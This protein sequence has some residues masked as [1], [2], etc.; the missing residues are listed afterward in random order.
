[1]SVAVWRGSTKATYHIGTCSD[2]DV[3]RDIPNFS[4]RPSSFA[5][6][7]ERERNRTIPN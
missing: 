3:K 2:D 1:M 4:E 5:S 7:S 6:L